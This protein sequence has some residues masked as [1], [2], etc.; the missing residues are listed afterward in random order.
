MKTPNSLKNDRRA[1]KPLME[2]RRRERINK[3]LNELKTIL[4]AAMRKDQSTCHSKLEKADILEMTVRFMKSIQ[5]RWTMDPQLIGV[6]TSGTAH[7]G[8]SPNFQ[9]FPNQPAAQQQ[10]S[11]TSSINPLY[12]EQQSRV[13]SKQHNSQNEM[14]SIRMVSHLGKKP[15][16][17][18]QQPNIQAHLQI[19]QHHHMMAVASQL[20]AQQHLQN[21]QLRS[22]SSSSA[23]SSS[24]FCSIPP[25]NTSPIT[26]PSSPIVDVQSNGE[27]ANYSSIS[28]SEESEGVWRPW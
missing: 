24:G 2:K 19:M 28:D 18:Q 11:Q 22:R 1:S 16:A 27:E 6:D 21:L 13:M 8:N 25:V 17:S 5:H 3:S 14:H 7:F 26:A 9:R 10:S 12:L 15:E 20:A 23:C 4:L